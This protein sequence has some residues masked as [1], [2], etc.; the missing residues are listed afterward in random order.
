MSLGVEIK[1][2]E[3]SGVR[4]TYGENKKL[5]GMETSIEEPAV[6]T[7]ALGSTTKWISEIQF[8]NLWT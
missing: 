2:S 7:K 5:V 4:R 3:R 1:D 6:V 8:M